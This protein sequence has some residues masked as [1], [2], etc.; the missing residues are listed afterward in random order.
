VSTEG[1]RADTR[2]SERVWLYGVLDTLI[3]LIPDALPDHSS[4]T[5]QVRLA[6]SVRPVTGQS[7]VTIPDPKGREYQLASEHIWQGQKPGF[8]YGYTMR[9]PALLYRG[10][11][12]CA[13]GQIVGHA[14]ISILGDPVT[15]GN[16]TWTRIPTLS[17]WVS[18][19]P[20]VTDIEHAVRVME[21]YRVFTDGMGNAPVP[22]D[23][24]H[25][26]VLLTD[27]QQSP[28]PPVTVPAPPE[29]NPRRR[30]DNRAL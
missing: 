29:R 22:D 19:A 5:P 11:E 9:N 10:H 28:R 13:I 26:A 18:V 30:P 16:L 25:A 3:A 6:L 23:L 2:A 4:G 8:G 12:V 7:G 15:N 14:A 21:A 1:E 27:P 20:H 17:A 24:L